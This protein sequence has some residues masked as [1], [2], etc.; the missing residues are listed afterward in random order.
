MNRSSGNTSLDGREAV[1][2]I[3]KRA[4]PSELFF[5]PHPPPPPPP[6]RFASFSSRSSNQFAIRRVR[7]PCL[8][9]GRA[10]HLHENAEK[11]AI[12]RIIRERERPGFPVSDSR[13]EPVRR[14]DAGDGK[15]EEIMP[16]RRKRETGGKTERLVVRGP[17]NCARVQPRILFPFSS[18][19]TILSRLRLLHLR[20]LHRRILRRL[21]RQLQLSI[22]RVAIDI[23]E[24]SSRP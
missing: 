5:P 9:N 13:H 4:M 21:L 6:F 18:F 19:P 20:F 12:G 22:G 24:E 23:Q 8:L 11:R 1:W 14:E 17:F 7:I 10:G 2:R 16:G 15:R 3:A